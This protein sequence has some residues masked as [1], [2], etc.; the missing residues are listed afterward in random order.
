MPFPTFSPSLSKTTR[1]QEAH[2]IEPFGYIS[3][4]MP[5]RSVDEVNTLA[6]MGEGSLVGSLFTADDDIARDVVLG[7]ASHHGR[8]MVINKES[9]KSRQGMDLLYLTLFMEDLEGLVEVKS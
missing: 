5:Y 6:K 4:V 2:S 1:L 7:T 8:I 3:T 9:A